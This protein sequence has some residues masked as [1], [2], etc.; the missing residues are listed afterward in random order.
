MAATASPAAGAGLCVAVS[1]EVLNTSSE[2]CRE[3]ESVLQTR[4]NETL[5]FRRCS[6]E[7]RVQKCSIGVIGND[8]EDLPVS[9][10]RVVGI[11]GDEIFRIRF[12]N[13]DGIA[14]IWD[15]AE[16][17][18]NDQF[19]ISAPKDRYAVTVSAAGYRD[20][21]STAAP[22]TPVR[23]RTIRLVPKPRVSGRV[24]SRRDGVPLSAIV[25]SDA[26]VLGKSDEDGR[27]DVTIDP[28]EVKTIDIEAPGF[29][30]RKFPL[31]PFRDRLDLG[32]IEVGQ[33][34][35]LEVLV[36]LPKT[37]PPPS[38]FLLDQ[39]EKDRSKRLLKSIPIIEGR[40]EA[41]DLPPG[42]YVVLLRGPQPLQQYGTVVPLLE[43]ER[44]TVTLEPD[45][46]SLSAKL[47]HGTDPLSPATLVVR[48]LRSKWEGTAETNEDGRIETELWQQGT[49]VTSVKSSRFSPPFVTLQSAG[50]D[51]TA[52]WDILIPAASAEGKVVDE[53]GAGIA[54]AK[55][56]LRSETENEELIQEVVTG[57]AG[58]FV[59]NAL[60]AGRHQLSATAPGFVTST[61]PW[62]FTSE[63]AQKQSFLLTLR[64]GTVRRVVVTDVVGRPISNARLLLVDRSSGS[65]IESM[66]TDLSGSAD[67][68]L[69]DSAATL[70]AVPPGGSFGFVDL[71]P[72]QDDQTIFL[73]VPR[74][75][76]NIRI[77]ASDGREPLSGLS[78]AVKTR[79]R[80]LP[81]ALL[82]QLTSLIRRLPETDL[83]GE[84][85]IPFLP[86][87]VYEL[88]VD[89]FTGFTSSSSVTVSLSEGEALVRM[90]LRPSGR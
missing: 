32:T 62:F 12:E 28:Q 76:G 38:V 8:K 80:I 23:F 84:M 40:G 14:W 78:L 59:F 46:I 39:N 15:V 42:D 1:G 87:G 10:F 41:T 75:T 6:S 31:P 9:N 16:S 13:S 68:K 58:E 64:R 53:A 72:L 79:G 17:E 60:K 37:D 48:E 63:Q 11:G 33:G 47:R 65:L 50:S 56:A 71:Q 83:N 51:A 20:A 18:I 86:A 57:K 67:V 35:T 66:V 77:M 90:V 30:G 61:S 22:E 89:S 36:T 55:V 7:K 3:P 19:R 74:S 27:F 5:I 70:Y 26:V 85:I 54:D 34:A 88:T 43:A 44:R 2:A 24:V 81:A 21:V 29:V 82:F 49:F 45:R 4:K 73:N 25:V 69:S 52:S